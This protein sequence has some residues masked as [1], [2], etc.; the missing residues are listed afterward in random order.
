MAHPELDVAVVGGGPAGLMAAER[1]ALAGARVAVFDANGSV[2]RKILLAGKGGLNL[3]HGEP[4]PRFIARYAEAADWLAPALQDF[5]PDSVRDF[6]ASLGVETFVGS[7]GRVFPR[8]LKAAPLLRRWQQRLRGMGVAFHLR[9]CW[10]GSLAPEDLTFQTPTGLVR[11]ASRALVLALGGGSWPRLGSDGAWLQRLEAAGVAVSPLAPANCG[12]EIPWGEAFRARFAG[13]PV[14]AVAA[15]LPGETLRVGEFVITDHGVEGSLVYALS[16]RLRQAIARDGAAVLRLDLLPDWSP[17]RVEAALARPR[18]KRS[19]SEY[20]RRSLNLA[21]AKIGL[22]REALAE[23]AVLPARQ[24]A[25]HLKALDLRLLA[26]RPLA[27]A[28]SSAGGVRAEALDST[29]MLQQFPGVFCAGEMLDW[30]APTGGY[31]LTACF[32]T[33]A[34]A[35]LAARGWARGKARVDEA[36]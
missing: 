25:V 20:L 10:S 26:P 9:H 8:D 6:A 7:S 33:G 18:A 29:F 24:L 28:I 36:P 32:A 27:E 3:T 13:S 1:A 22:L 4:L 12:F 19:W 15:G 31:L 2:G 17:D 34:A 14:K 11:R 16:A 30:E 35:G 23:P 5:P 21:P